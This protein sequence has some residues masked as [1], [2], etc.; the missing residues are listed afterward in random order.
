ML[1]KLLEDFARLSVMYPQRDIGDLF[2]VF[3]D[4]TDS[5]IYEKVL[6][7]AV[8]FMQV[9]EAARSSRKEGKI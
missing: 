8:L 4:R 6:E 1:G 3:V 7:N 2:N 5:G 9:A